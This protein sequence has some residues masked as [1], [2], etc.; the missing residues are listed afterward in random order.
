MSRCERSL[1]SPFLSNVSNT[2]RDLENDADLATV[3]YLDLQDPPPPPRL[4][5]LFEAKEISRED[6]HEAMAVHARGLIEEMEEQRRSPVAAW[7]E[8]S[9]NRRAAEK[10]KRDYDEVALRETLSAVAETPNFP[11]SN[12]LW[13]AMHRDVPLHCFV[14]SRHE[15]VLRILHF[16]SQPMT[17]E[18]IIE[19]GATRKKDATR[20]RFRLKRIWNGELAVDKREQLA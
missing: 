19:H 14:R 17:S 13:N 8:N 16:A 20:E 7:V 4:F 15:P 11:P 6:L 1:N 12:L 18:V 9:R 10:L 2:R 5:Q 3:F